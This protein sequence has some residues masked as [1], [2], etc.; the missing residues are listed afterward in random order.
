MDL[1]AKYKENRGAW[2]KFLMA[3]PFTRLKSVE[4]ESLLEDMRERAA[5][6]KVDAKV[7]AK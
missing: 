6:A 1:I 2:E 5:D 3:E 7:D 4:V